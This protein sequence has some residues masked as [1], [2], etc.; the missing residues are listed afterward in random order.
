VD[1]TIKRVEEALATVGD[2]AKPHLALGTLYLRKQDPARAERAFQDAVARE[3]KSVEAHSLLGSLYLL[4]RDI[5]Q[6][7]R[8]FKTAADLAP[9]GSPARLRL[10]R[11]SLPLQ[12]PAAAQPL[13]AGGSPKGPGPLPP[14]RRAP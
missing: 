11:F 7:E 5:A 10:A 9:I 6:A 8:E 14:L 13:P 4:K 2:R 3:P 12:K 1:A